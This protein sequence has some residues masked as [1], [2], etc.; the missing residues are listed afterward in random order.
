MEVD[1]SLYEGDLIVIPEFQYYLDFFYFKFPN[2]F[3]QADSVLIWSQKP[4][5]WC[6]T[7]DSHASHLA[8]WKQFRPN[9][10][11][12]W[13]KLQYQPR[14]S[15]CRTNLST[16]VKRRL[17]DWLTDWLTDCYV[18]MCVFTLAIRSGCPWSWGL[19]SQRIFYWI[20]YRTLRL[21]L[22]T[23]I[24]GN[25]EWF[26]TFHPSSKTLFVIRLFLSC[27]SG[28]LLSTKTAI[29]SFDQITKIYT[30]P[31]KQMIQVKEMDVINSSHSLSSRHHPQL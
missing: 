24:F 23:W 10:R 8:D 9:E 7:E 22:A 13:V 25:A 14:W 2:E 17:C 29:T 27:D 1:K 6:C 19:P 15:Y 12:N 30:K 20:N 26:P 21:R 18:C 4:T 31:T 16:E 3:Q 11:I 28:K 5:K